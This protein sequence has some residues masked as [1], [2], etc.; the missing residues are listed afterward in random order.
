MA[1]NY[2]IYIFY[3]N[4]NVFSHDEYIYIYI[5]IRTTHIIREI[6]KIDETYKLLNNWNTYVH[7]T[8]HEIFIYKD[9]DYL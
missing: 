2:N 4:C 3:F 6:I 9:F 8:K 7:N 5:H 1:S